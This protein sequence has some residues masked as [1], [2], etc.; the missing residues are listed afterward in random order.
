LVHQTAEDY[1]LDRASHEDLL[2]CCCW[3]VDDVSEATGDVHTWMWVPLEGRRPNFV[4]HYNA[5]TTSIGKPWIGIRRFCSKPWI[6]I[7]RV[8]NFTKILVPGLMR[9]YSPANTAAMPWKR[10]QKKELMN[11]VIVSFSKPSNCI[12]IVLFFISLTA[13]RSLQYRS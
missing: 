10:S 8:C 3:L 13:W 4:R 2:V 5:H 7:R 9:A 12:C 11:L 1:R 6:E